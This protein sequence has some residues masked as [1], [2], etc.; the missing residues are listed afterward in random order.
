MIERLRYFYRAIEPFRYI[1][2]F[3][4]PHTTRTQC[5]QPRSEIWHDFIYA[6][7]RDERERQ[8]ECSV[9]FLKV[10]FYFKQRANTTADRC[11]WAL[12][13]L[14]RKGRQLYYRRLHIYPVPFHTSASHALSVVGDLTLCWDASLFPFYRPPLTPASPEHFRRHY[15]FWAMTSF[16]MEQLRI[17]RARWGRDEKEPII[18]WWALISRASPPFRCCAVYFWRH[19]DTDFI[20]AASISVRSH[21]APRKVISTSRQRFEAYCAKIMRLSSGRTPWWLILMRSDLPGASL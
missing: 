13:P 17:T 3:P 8:M 10:I 9:S 1:H 6:W 4:P 16:M 14:A 5:S 12:S 15:D 19:A 11:A 7:V 20:C 2:R 21:H 18:T